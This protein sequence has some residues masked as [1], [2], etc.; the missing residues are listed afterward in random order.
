MNCCEKGTALLPQSELL[1]ELKGCR[2]FEGIRKA[3]YNLNN[4]R[5]PVIVSKNPEAP[6]EKLVT[7]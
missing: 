7:G 3:H 1:L 5:I 6:L 4:N 2:E